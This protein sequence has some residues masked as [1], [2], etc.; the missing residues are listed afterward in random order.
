MGDNCL[1]LPYNS[2]CGNPENT[3]SFIKKAIL[4]NGRTAQS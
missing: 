3:E 1:L 2:V 4:S